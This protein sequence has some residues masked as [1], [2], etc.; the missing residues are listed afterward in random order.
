M[1][2]P[3]TPADLDSVA[4]L[5]N[6]YRIFYEKPTAL[7]EGRQFLADRMDRKESVVFVAETDS[8]TLAGFVQLYPLFSS[9]RMKRLWLLNDLF[10][11]ADHR[12]QGHSLALIDA[13]RQL[14]RETKACGLI[15]ETAQT[16]LIGNRLYP[17]AGFVLDEEHNY[18]SWDV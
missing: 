4:Y 14:C 15:L 5:F 2:R 7:A 17:R 16:N 9:T 10:V 12:G 3:A 13:A 1:T 11:H 6:E 8:G 18:Y